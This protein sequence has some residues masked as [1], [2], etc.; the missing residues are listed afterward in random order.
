MRLSREEVILLL[1]VAINVLA[2]IVA[3][4]RADETIEE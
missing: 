2:T 1:Q 3:V 4:L